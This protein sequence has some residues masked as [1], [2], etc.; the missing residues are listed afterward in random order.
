MVAVVVGSFWGG[1]KFLSHWP[2]DLVDKAERALAPPPDLPLA[3]NATPA[4]HGP[5]LE[6]EST[7]DMEVFDALP[8]GARY[9]LNYADDCYSASNVLLLAASKN[10]DPHTL[11]YVMVEKVALP[12][13]HRPNPFTWLDAPRAFARAGA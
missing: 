9:A 5:V 10:M 13:K 11:G 7:L 6:W 1:E 4:A 2:S 12:A 3:G 8:P